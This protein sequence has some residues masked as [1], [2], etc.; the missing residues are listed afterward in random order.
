[1]FQCLIGRNGMN[2]EA[3]Q[4]SLNETEITEVSTNKTIVTVQKFSVYDWP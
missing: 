3:N 4:I 2:L 1:M